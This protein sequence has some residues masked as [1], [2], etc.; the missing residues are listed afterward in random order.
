MHAEIKQVNGLTMMGK[1][2]SNHW[3]VMDGPKIYKGSEAATRPMEM[4]LIALGGCLGMD[5]VSLL[6]KKKASLDNI[7]IEIDAEEA[8]D[9]PRVFTRI[10]VKCL[11]KGKKLNEDDVRWALN[12]AYEKYCPV[13]AML[14]EVADINYSYEIVES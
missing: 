2:N 14:S 5:I 4:V 10:D 6:G 12:K 11:F 3:V 7:K 9:H 13:G 1:A 8:K